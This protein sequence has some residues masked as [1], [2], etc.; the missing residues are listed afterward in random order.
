MQR[1]AEAHAAE[2]KKK[3]ELAE[4]RNTA[5]QRV[6]QLE[7]TL[8]ESKDKLS[9]ADKEAVK[10]AI[11]AVNE[12]KKGTTSPRSTRPSRTSD[13]PA[14]PWPSIFTPRLGAAPTGRRRRTA[15]ATDRGSA[16]GGPKA[17]DVIDVEFEEKK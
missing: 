17:D 7:K 5:E 13:G 16:N 10:T 2:D 15:V 12:A 11:A 9:D 3:R 6:Y 14:R 1:D 8:E 4:A